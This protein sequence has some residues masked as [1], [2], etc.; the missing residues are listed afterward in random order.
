MRR[1]KRKARTGPSVR[2]FLRYYALVL[3]ET[4]QLTSR[5]LIGKIERESACNCDYRASG[6]LLVDEQE[7]GRVLEQLR[8][9][10]LASPAGA[11]WRLT[12]QGHRKLQTYKKQQG[13]CPNGKERAAKLLLKWMARC[14]AGERVLDVGTGEGYLAFKVADQGCLALGIDSGSFDYSKDSVKKARQKAEGR[15]GQVEF[16]RRSVTS[17]RGRDESFD[18]VI[19]SQAIHCMKD[20]HQC[21][22]AVH[23]LLKPG[24]SFLCM[25]FAVGLKGFLQHGWHAFLGISQEEWKAL[26]PQCGFEEPRVRTVCDYLLVMARKGSSAKQSVEVAQSKSQPVTLRGNQRAYCCSCDEDGVLW[27]RWAVANGGCYSSG[28]GSGH[29]IAAGDPPAS[30][31]VDAGSRAVQTPRS[32]VTVL[33]RTWRKVKGLLRAETGLATPVLCRFCEREHMEQ[34]IG[35]PAFG[36]LKEQTDQA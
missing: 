14:E 16:L 5:G 27:K 1:R 26:L 11:K 3:L 22:K 30:G 7:L 32:L 34:L 13:Q 24:G 20:Q 18:Y 33:R 23:R 36:A 35:L 6:Q 15:G 8:K 4:E 21:V 29:A 10:S 9:N 31:N 25:D 12:R 2:E 19:T 28:L 17:L